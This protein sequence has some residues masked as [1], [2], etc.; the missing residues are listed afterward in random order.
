MKNAASIL[1]TS[2]QLI[3]INILL[4]CV[5]HFQNHLKIA[6]LNENKKMIHFVPRLLNKT[7]EMLERDTIS[8]PYTAESYKKDLINKKFDSISRH[9]EIHKYVHRTEM[10]L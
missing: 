6:I 9:M 8:I 10:M 4:K 2:Y 3:M 5:N 1:L 7:S